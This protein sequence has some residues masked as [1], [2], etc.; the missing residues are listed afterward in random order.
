MRKLLPALSFA[1]FLMSCEKPTQV[2]S[3]P[4]PPAALVADL[5]AQPLVPVEATD[6]GV[7]SYIVA[8]REYGR[9]VAARF[10]ALRVWSLKPKEDR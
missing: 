2:A 7:G 9:T 8:L 3:L 10:E 1:L 5:P 6:V 4:T